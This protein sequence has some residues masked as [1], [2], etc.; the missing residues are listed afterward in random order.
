MDKRKDENNGYLIKIAGSLDPHWKSWFNGMEISTE[1]LEDGKP[2]TIL[3]GPVADQ[4]ALRGLLTR[5]WDLNLELIAVQKLS[6][7]LER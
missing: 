7:P 3:T 2:I 1:T 4:V 6:N 5:I